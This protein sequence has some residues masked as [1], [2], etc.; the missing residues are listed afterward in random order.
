MKRKNSFFKLA[1]FAF[2]ISVSVVSCSNDEF[3]G[4]DSDFSYYDNEKNLS[5]DN[6][7]F[8]NIST[9]D[10]RQMTN[11][12]YLNLSKAIARI[13]NDFN[14][15]IAKESKGYTY[16][17]SNTLYTLA[18]TT[19][20]NTRHFFATISSNTTKRVKNNNREVVFEINGKDC[21]GQAIAYSLYP[22]KA[23]SINSILANNFSNYFSNGIPY[24][25]L[26][27]AFDK[28]GANY[29]PYSRLYT[30]ETNTSSSYDVLIIK[31]SSGDYHAMN[32]L[33]VAECG[34]YFEV[35]AHDKNYDGIYFY[36]NRATFPA[37]FHNGDNDYQMISSYHLTKKK[38]SN[39][40]K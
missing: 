1:L 15:G 22:G 5:F 17:M 20:D 2:V 12:D 7:L 31:P 34:P 13:E 26:D 33:S 28:C 36:A 18:Y 16:N 6:E 21:V 24:L 4:F 9:S 29:T 32:I 35:Y 14:N 3:F 40:I 8:L 39:K 38:I 30:T 25:S 37:T 10:F 27:T 23:D 19:L 11:T